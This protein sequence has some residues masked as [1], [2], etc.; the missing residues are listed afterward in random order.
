MNQEQNNLNPN[1][2]NTQGSNG[3]PNNQPLNNQNF[4]QG[5][6]FNQQPINP[7]PQPTPSYQQP[8]MQEPTPQPTNT[9]ESGNANNQSFNSK[10][11]KK[12]N[13]GLIIGIVAVV[14]VVGVGVVFGSKLLSKGN[15]DLDNNPNN[16]V[17]E[18]NNNK[19]SNNS[20]NN[21]IKKEK[22][23]AVTAENAT[24]KDDGSNETVGNIPSGN[25]SVGDEYV[26]KV[27]DTHYYHFYILSDNGD[28]TVNL[29]MDK[30]LLSNGEPTTKNEDGKV[31]WY[32]DEESAKYGPVTAMN[33]IYKATKNWKIG[34]VNV[35][36]VDANGTYGGI[37]TDGTTTT[38]T[39]ING[40]VTATYENLKARLPEYSELEN[41]GC[42][43]SDYGIDCPLWVYNY[44]QNGYYS[45]WTP[46]TFKLS[47]SRAWVLSWG[48]FAHTLV[49]DAFEGNMTIGVRVVITMNKSDLK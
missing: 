15:E 26:I 28:G 47:S 22:E 16:S 14:A 34:N 23:G 12:M 13:L 37:K 21:G 24:Y 18:N 48:K 11:P 6:G 8:I 5:M 1:N 27:D 42:S 38:I 39:D 45:Y 36:F 4:N 33:Y 25:Y 19:P 35:N 44:L 40:N 3:I 20:N 46:T 2:F 30:N 17:T 9:F 31:E 29:I 10:P 49:N 7:Q 32:A 41:V 43:T